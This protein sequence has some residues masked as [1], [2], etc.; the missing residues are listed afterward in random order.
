MNF[1]HCSAYQCVNK[2]HFL[3]MLGG[4]EATGFWTI[5]W[6]FLLNL[7]VASK[8]R[9]VKKGLIRRDSL[10]DKL[11]FGKIQ[12]CWVD[13]DGPGYVSGL[14]SASA[15]FAFPLMVKCLFNWRPFGTFCVH[16]AF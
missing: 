9:E 2:S 15:Y 16:S 10:W 7:A 3:L 13:P 14:P 11:I 5:F 4:K 6:K 1:H 8:F 12:V